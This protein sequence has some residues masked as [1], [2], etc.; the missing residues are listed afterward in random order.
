MLIFHQVL[1]DTSRL[2]CPLVVKVSSNFVANRNYADS[3]EK[4]IINFAR[5]KH[6]ARAKQEPEPSLGVGVAMAI[7]LFLLTVCASIGQHQVSRT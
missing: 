7:G 1:G 3:Y 5:A 6:A 4:A 2:M